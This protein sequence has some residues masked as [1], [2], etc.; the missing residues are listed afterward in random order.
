MKN[1]SETT[2]VGKASSAQQNPAIATGCKKNGRRMI[3]LDFRNSTIV[4]LI[5]II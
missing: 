3:F 2:Q 1:R 4:E 5:E